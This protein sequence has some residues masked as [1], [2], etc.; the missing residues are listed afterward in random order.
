V[1]RL[2]RIPFVVQN[3][4]VPAFHKGITRHSHSHKSIT[5]DKYFYT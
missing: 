2:L 4:Y 5:E 3:V 1:G